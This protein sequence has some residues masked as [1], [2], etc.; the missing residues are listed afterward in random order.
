[1]RVVALAGRRIDAPGTTTSRFPLAKVPLVRARLREEF[2]ALQAKALVC[3]AACGADLVAGQ[4]A[5]DLAIRVKLILPFEVARF[6]ETSVVDRPGDWGPTF[7]QIVEHAR[8]QDDLQIIDSR[9][10]ES[11]AYAT[12]NS[13]ILDNAQQLAA[14]ANVEAVALIVWEGESRGKGDLT[15]AFRESAEKRR[16]RVLEVLT[17]DTTKNRLV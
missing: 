9:G 14:Q 4:V 13:S 7:D 16:L 17:L 12:V 5:I 11:E 1:M 10:D 8:A 15:E 3:S 2:Q 6:R